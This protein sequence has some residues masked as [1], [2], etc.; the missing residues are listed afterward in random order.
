MSQCHQGCLP[1]L[2]QQ[3][4][5]QTN[6][7]AGNGTDVHGD[8]VKKIIFLT[9][10]LDVFV[11]RFIEIIRINGFAPSANCSKIGP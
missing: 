1:L 3:A 11:G 2:P 10:L 5:L 9:P 6:A 8:S 7:S 4:A